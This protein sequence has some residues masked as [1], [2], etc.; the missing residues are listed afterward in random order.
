VSLDWAI[1]LLNSLLQWALVAMVLRKD[2]WRKH[3]A[4]AI[5]I[6]FCSCKTTLL[7]WIAVYH[8]PLYYSTNWGARLVGLPLMIAVLFE[9][10]AA[11][12]RPYSTLPNGALRYFR[13]AL[14]T[15]VLLTACAAFCFPG[16]SPRSVENTVFLLNRSAAI[17]FCGAFGF[18]ALASSYYGIP[19][20]T[21]TYGI[22]VGFLLYMSVD[23]F[24]ASAI[25]GHGPMAAIALR[26]VGMLSYTLGLI[27]WINYFAIPDLAS[28]S[29]SLEQMRRL[30]KALDSV[31]KKVGC[32]RTSE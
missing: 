19:W 18:T 4:F 23:I 24:T 26:K 3:T 2:L 22:G 5:Y 15:L 12:F 1:W 30:Q 17:I 27:T 7:M 21:R 31:E 9:V 8:Q 25:A 11:V 29:P 14:V 16:A 28:K 10:F 32:S 6:V 13:I 20:Q